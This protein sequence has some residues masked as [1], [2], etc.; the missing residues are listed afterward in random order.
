MV[1][2]DLGWTGKHHFKSFQESLYEEQ[3]KN[4]VNTAVIQPEKIVF[5]PPKEIKSEITIKRRNM[6]EVMPFYLENQIKTADVIKSEKIVN[7]G[8]VKC[9]I[10]D[11]EFSSKENRTSH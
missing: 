5:K 6:E 3:L 10:C 4:H 1:S 2:H 7:S 9:D 11:H 8:G